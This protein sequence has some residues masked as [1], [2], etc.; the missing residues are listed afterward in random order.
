MRIALIAKPG[1]GN[2]G[3]GRYT[4]Q[5]QR[6]LEALGHEV[7]IVYPVVPIPR[8]LAKLIYQ[9]LHRDLTAFFETYPVWVRY[10]EADIYHITSQ[11]L[12]TLMILRRPPGPS[13]VT[14]HDILPFTSPKIDGYFVHAN[15]IEKWMSFLALQGIHKMPIVLSVSSFTK[16]Q[17]ILHLG[18]KPERVTVTLE[19]C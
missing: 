14:V 1:H 16:A 10:P 6:E 2:T 3:V 5:L 12:A 15:L 17:T 7:V 8:S 18:F 13:V 4:V 9:L 19:G 11:N